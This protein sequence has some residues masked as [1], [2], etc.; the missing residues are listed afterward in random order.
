MIA[1]KAYL[2][3]ECCIR[4]KKNESGTFSEDQVGRLATHVPAVPIPSFL[5][6]SLLCHEMSRDRGKMGGSGDWESQ[7]LILS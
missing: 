4:R 6:P 1:C 3:T 5:F 7:W 2:S